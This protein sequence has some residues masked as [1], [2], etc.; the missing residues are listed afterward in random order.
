MLIML[1]IYIADEFLNRFGWLALIE[2]EIT[3]AHRLF[4]SSG[5]ILEIFRAMLFKLKQIPYS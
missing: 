2:R 1:H 4:Q 5:N 3:E